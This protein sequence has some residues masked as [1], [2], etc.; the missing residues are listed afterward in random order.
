M[1]FKSPCIVCNKPL[2]VIGRQRKN[3]DPSHNDWNTRKTHKQCYSTYLMY[4]KQYDDQQ[5]KQVK[6]KRRAIL[7]AEAKRS[8]EGPIIWTED[9]IN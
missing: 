9:D 8:G 6:L 1:D 4:K 2:H 5:E 7:E 3:G